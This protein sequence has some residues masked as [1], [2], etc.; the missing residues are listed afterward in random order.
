ML[1]ISTGDSSGEVFGELTGESRRSEREEPSE[2]LE[3]AVSVLV[4]VS[5]LLMRVACCTRGWRERDKAGFVLLSAACW[6]VGA[7][8]CCVLAV[9]RLFGTVLVGVD[10]EHSMAS[11]GMAIGMKKGLIVWTTM[12]D[13]AVV[14]VHGGKVVIHFPTQAMRLS[15]TW[16]SKRTGF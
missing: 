16:C 13:L 2:S 5:R 15:C 3:H 8:S 1:A 6:M 7:H 12:A 11:F 14:S 9:S 4:A 10:S